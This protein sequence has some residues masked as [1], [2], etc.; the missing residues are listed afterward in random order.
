M[1]A[2]KR[3][4]RKGKSVAVSVFHLI[5]LLFERIPTEEERTD[6]RKSTQGDAPAPAEAEAA[7]AEPA[8]VPEVPDAAAATVAAA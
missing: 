8:P 7:P 5:N 6:E 2:K 1:R 3:R 4:K